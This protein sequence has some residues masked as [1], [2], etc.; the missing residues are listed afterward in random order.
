MEFLI[1]LIDSLIIWKKVSLFLLVYKQSYYDAKTQCENLWN[2]IFLLEPKKIE[3][4]IND[5]RLLISKYV[6]D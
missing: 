3:G 4:K 1:Y 6:F 2:I 5:N